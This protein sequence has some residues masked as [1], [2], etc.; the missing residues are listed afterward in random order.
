MPIE[1]YSI[2]WDEKKSVP[3][4]VGRLRISQQ[5]L[6]DALDQQGEHMIFTPWNNT[7]DFRP[8][9]SLNRAPKNRLQLFGPQAS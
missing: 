2:V 9:G 1:D 8:L 3:I 6:D 4:H 5:K 7:K